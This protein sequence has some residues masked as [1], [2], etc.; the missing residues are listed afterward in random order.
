[1]RSFGRTSGRQDTPEKTGRRTRELTVTFQTACGLKRRSFSPL[2][3]E[4]MTM[5]N[6]CRYSPALSVAICLG[7]L[8]GCQSQRST[9]LNS[10][11]A[12]GPAGAVEISPQS[13][14][15]T[16]S[17]TVRNPGTYPLRKGLRL[18]DAIR[19]A[20]GTTIE[21]DK[22]GIIVIRGGKRI[23]VSPPAYDTPLKDF[24][25]EEEKRRWEKVT[26][27]KFPLR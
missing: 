5:H 2:A 24:W 11:S 14:S 6:L 25:T 22:A 17:G 3:Q 9:S 13:G 16:I 21:S 27:E 26:G 8:A 18:S 20:G 10:T 15:Y 12:P 4:M 7:V 1:M 19:I 23:F